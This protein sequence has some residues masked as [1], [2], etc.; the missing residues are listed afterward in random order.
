MDTAKEKLRLYQVA[1]HVTANSIGE[2]QAMFRTAMNKPRCLTCEVIESPTGR[3]DPILGLTQNRLEKVDAVFTRK[4]FVYMADENKYG[5]VEF[6]QGDN[7]VG[8]RCL[9]GTTYVKP[10]SR[11]M[12]TNT[13]KD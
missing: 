4:D 3:L 1:F 9:D 6:L 5:R 12:H 10:R 11:L 2:A 8:V 13:N 7:L